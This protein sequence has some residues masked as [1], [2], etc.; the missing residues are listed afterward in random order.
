MSKVGE[1]GI[2]GLT[3]TRIRA[4]IAHLTATFRK[5]RQVNHPIYVSLTG[6]H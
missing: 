6:Q 3:A 5:E 1:T 2:L 4:I